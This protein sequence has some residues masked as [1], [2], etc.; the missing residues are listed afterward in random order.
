MSAMEKH[1]PMPERSHK[2]QEGQRPAW[3]VSTRFDASALA[4]DRARGANADLQRQHG[5]P[6]LRRYLD[7]LKISAETA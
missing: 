7:D 6:V 3:K 1:R 5:R 2:L 4:G